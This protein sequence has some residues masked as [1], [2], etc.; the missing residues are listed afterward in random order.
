MACLV[1]HAGALGDFI[2]ALPA[3]RVWRRL[4][5][6]GRMVLLGRPAHAALCGSLFDEA[7]DSASAR[8]ASLFG[9]APD[10][11]LAGTMRG[12]DAALLFSPASSPLAAGL[13]ALG[14]RGIVRQDPFPPDSAGAGQLHVVD[15][16]LS[17]FPP[18][19]VTDGERIP[20]IECADLREAGAVSPGT[21]AIAF[22]SGSE[23]K[24]WPL[25]RFAALAGR[26]AARG[27]PV[28]WIAGPAEQGAWMPREWPAWR[29][30][31]LSVLASRLARCALY[32]GNDSG[33][34]HLA[35]AAGCPSI[36]LFGTTNPALWAPRGARV[37]IVS[38]GGQG[39]EGIGLQEVL[40]RA[41]HFIAANAAEL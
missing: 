11:R 25:E 39:M 5:P 23:R 18:W 28:A 4:H 12:F 38:S 15:H 14:V 34:S 33:V 22:G 19:A 16:H 27:A 30:C 21:V 24:N 1:S 13:A 6:Q 35:A 41:E 29:E 3:M 2:T 10:P 36:V 7:W 37:S 40:E 17:L 32:V 26:L 8:L 9:G 31:S 20:L